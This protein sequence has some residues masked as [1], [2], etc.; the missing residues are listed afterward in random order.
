MYKIANGQ[1]KI[2]FKQFFFPSL[3]QSLGFIPMSPRLEALRLR[4][5][6]LQH[7]VGT[8]PQHHEI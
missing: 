2:G 5:F 7:P 1:L 8:L 3:P 6:S 4:G